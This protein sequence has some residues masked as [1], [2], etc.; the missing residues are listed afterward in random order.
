[1]D[2]YF[3]FI[4]LIICGLPGLIL[5]FVMLNIMESKGENINPFFVTPS[6]Y[7][8][9]WRIIK[10]EKN[11]S[12]KYKYLLIFWIQIAIMPIYMT[13]GILIIKYLS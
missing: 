1:M 6:Q 11:K 13:G 10:N 2:G 4:W 3:I 12:K 9:F 7:I 8:K 5:W